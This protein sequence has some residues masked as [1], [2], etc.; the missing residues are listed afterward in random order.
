[1]VSS[2][3]PW[4]FARCVTSNS[5]TSTSFALHPST[6]EWI[7]KLVHHLPFT[8]EELAQLIANIKISGHIGISNIEKNPKDSMKEPKSRNEEPLVPDPALPS[9][10]LPDTS[11]LQLRFSHLLKCK[12]LGHPW[13]SLQLFLTL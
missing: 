1:M 2:Q 13:H 4:L 7:I 6:S 5:A 8:W 10:H 3:D 12:Q 11:L 9:A